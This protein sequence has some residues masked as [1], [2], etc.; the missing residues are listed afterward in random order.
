MTRDRYGSVDNFGAGAAIKR[1]YGLLVSGEVW[2]SVCHLRTDNVCHF[3]ARG[4]RIWECARQFPARA[5]D[6]DNCAGELF[7]YPAAP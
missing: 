3:G 1:N 7:Q 6:N 2:F 5:C 4:S